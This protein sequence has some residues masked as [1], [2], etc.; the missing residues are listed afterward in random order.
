MN[1]FHGRDK[2]SH[3]THPNPVSSMR[4]LQLRVRMSLTIVRFEAKDMSSAANVAWH[5]MWSVELHRLTRRNTSVDP[6][7]SWWTYR[8]PEEIDTDDS[9]W[10]SITLTIEVFF[11]N[12]FSFGLVRR[13]EIID[14]HADGHLCLLTIYRFDSCSS[15]G[16]RISP[17]A[18]NVRLFPLVPSFCISGHCFW[19]AGIGWLTLIEI[20]RPSTATESNTYRCGD[21]ATMFNHISTVG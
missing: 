7:R 5:S 12:D 19:S 18:I 16:M 4:T 1:R 13:K 17:R 10:P 15:I 8:F 2:A 21:N 9:T 3:I 20:R 6:C 11:C 14:F